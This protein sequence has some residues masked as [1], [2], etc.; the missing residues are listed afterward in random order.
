M[1]T[2]A[3]RAVDALKFVAIFAGLMLFFYEA[4]LWLDRFDVYSH[5]YDNPG[6]DAVQVFQ[7]GDAEHQLGHGLTRRF[8]EFIRDGE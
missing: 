1:R 5:R 2:A 4:M 3:G 6:S 8:L 7:T